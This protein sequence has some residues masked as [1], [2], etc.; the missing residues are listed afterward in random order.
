MGGRFD[1]GNRVI[2]GESDTSRMGR[3]VGSYHYD[4]DHEGWKAVAATFSI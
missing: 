3:A 4:E 2:I 1:R